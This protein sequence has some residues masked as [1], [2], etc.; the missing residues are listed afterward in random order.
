MSFTNSFI[1]YKCIETYIV[2]NEIIIFEIYKRLQ[3]EH[4]FFS[5]FKSLRKYNK[6][7]IKRLIIYYLL[8]ILNMHDYKKKSYFILIIQLKQHDLIFEKS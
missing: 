5:K 4:Y 7:L 6:Q 1:N 2:I 8:F 3:I